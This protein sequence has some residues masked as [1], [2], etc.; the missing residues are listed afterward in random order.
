MKTIVVL[1][2]LLLCIL[3]CNFNNFA[4]CQKEATQKKLCLIVHLSLNDQQID[5]FLYI[6]TRDSFFNQLILIFFKDSMIGGEEVVIRRY[7]KKYENIIYVANWNLKNTK[8]MFLGCAQIIKTPHIAYTFCNNNID[9]K[10]LKK[11]VEFLESS[12]EKGAVRFD[13][14]SDIEKDISVYGIVFK[15]SLL[16]NIMNQ[17][18]QVLAEA[19]FDV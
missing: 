19:R 3:A 14:Y 17:D 13:E 15:R 1:Q 9:M 8:A 12:T 18:S 7:Q 5:D 16:Q 2:W 4:I 10:K 11:A 6:L